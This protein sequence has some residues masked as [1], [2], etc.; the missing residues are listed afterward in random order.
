[1]D[2]IDVEQ[3]A[4]DFVVAL[5]SSGA[6]KSSQDGFLEYENFIN[7]METGGQIDPEEPDDDDEDFAEELSEDDI[8]EEDLED[9]E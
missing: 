9:S 6:V 4:R 2:R 1:M 3:F 5:A 7:C 8:E